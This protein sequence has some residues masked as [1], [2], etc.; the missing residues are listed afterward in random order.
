MSTPDRNE[1]FTRR[2][3]AA[4]EQLAG[5]VAVGTLAALGAADACCDLTKRVMPGDTEASVSLLVADRATTVV[6]TGQ[7]ALDLDESQYAHGYGPCLAR[8]R[9][10]R[11]DRGRRTPAPTRDGRTTWQRAVERGQP[12]LDVGAL[13]QSRS[14]SARRS[15]STP[16]RR[17]PS[18]TRAGASAS[19]VRRA[20]PA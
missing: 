4:L 11:T 6:Y 16:A 13:G 10:R 18:T 17:P 12:E 3:R 5:I 19:Q 8:G 20:S 9:Q 15:T 1:T 7:L 14:R 2:R